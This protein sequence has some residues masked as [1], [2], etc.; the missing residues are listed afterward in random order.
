[1]VGKLLVAYINGVYKSYIILS[2]HIQG[3]KESEH[4]SK[5]QDV[6]DITNPTSKHH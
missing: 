2:Q 4:V 6:V 1:M 5:I 3:R